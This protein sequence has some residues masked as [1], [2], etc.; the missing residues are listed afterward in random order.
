MGAYLSSSS[1]CS[2]SGEARISRKN[3]PEDLYRKSDWEKMCN[4]GG[5]FYGW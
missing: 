2:S 1:W 5:K 4:D 3:A